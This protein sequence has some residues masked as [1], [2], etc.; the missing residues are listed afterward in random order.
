[1]EK[2]QLVYP[3]AWQA[4]GGLRHI[5]QLAWPM[6]LTAVVV[7]LS[8]NGQLW[9]LGT[10]DNGQQAL[11]TLS[12]LQPFYF[13]FIALLEGLTIT[14]QIFS[15]RS[16][17]NWAPRKVINSTALFSLTGTLF[18][19]LFALASWAGA[20][21]LQN[22][23]PGDEPALFS[24]ILPA[25][26][27]SVI[28]LLLLEL[29]NA[30]LRGQGK[31]A[32]SMV[33]VAAFIL[34]NLSSCY[35]S[36]HLYHNGFTAVIY[37]NLIATLAV[38]PFAVL[39]LLKTVPKGEDPQPRAFMPRLMAITADAGVPIFLTML[40][41]FASSAVL[42][43]LLSKMGTAWASG[44][45]IV[46]KLRTFFIIPA[47]ALGSAIAI[48]INQKLATC[49]PQQLNRLLRVGMYSI[50]LIYL[51]L[52]LAA[53]LSQ[54]QLINLMAT[55]SEVRVSAYLLMSWLI[56]TFFITSLIASIQTILEQLG[57]GK[58]VLLI[59][60]AMESL[61]VAT[62]LF[63]ARQPDALLLLM[64]SILLFNV[65]YLLVFAYEYWLLCSRVGKAHVV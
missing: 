36:L 39:A 26:M 44:F 17:S 22:V 42:F 7:S 38:L 24:T 59:T 34:I 1:M 57:R 54:N 29:C 65:F 25:Y 49:S 46:V 50:A 48:C 31:T 64:K 2:Q 43:P 37:A 60:L 14:N 33:F 51:C 55:S 47:V 5:L 13:I 58:R 10:Q 41:A 16:V 53:F 9:I 3:A 15:A 23:Y 11:Y 62:V 45:L 19:L 21:W 8:Q 28:P 6:I 30:G 52:T 32:L 12:M 27:L 56:P 40:L 4:E 63:I 35:I 18:L 61:M 20:S